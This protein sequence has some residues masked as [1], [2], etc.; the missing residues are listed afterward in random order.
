MST[1]VG[2][3]DEGMRRPKC[4]EACEAVAAIRD[5]A[6]VAVGGFVGAAHPE[7]LT[8]A[9]EGRFQR[10]ARPRDL[11]LI[12]A[13]G[14]GDGRSRGLNH[15]AH[16]GLLA[17]VI[18]GHWNLAPGLGELAAAGQI[19]AY[20]FPQGVISLLFR[21]IAAHR[22]GL[23]TH[24]GLE[25]FIDPLYGGGKLNDRTRIDLVQRVELNGKTWLFYPSLPIDVALIR[26]TTADC[27]GNLTMEREAL[28]GEVLP[29]AQA[30]RN[31]GGIVIAQ[32][33][34][35][36]EAP[37]PPQHVRV[38]GALID[39]LVVADGAQHDQTFASH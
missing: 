36:T 34:G 8:A 24:V 35:T 16:E 4:V 1:A 17:R 9:I 12:Y 18:G 38:P 7:A 31:S 5:G 37:H 13:A 21:E 19:E 11:T 32:V 10:E 30:A 26:G 15:L 3:A 29:M 33:A 28:I 39:M 22:P 25:T 20:N 14:Q 23:I 2:T 6:T 27:F